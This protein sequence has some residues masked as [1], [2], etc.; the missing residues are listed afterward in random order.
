MKSRHMRT[1]EVGG[2]QGRGPAFMT[3][4]ADADAF[5]GAFC[6][7]HR[8][9]RRLVRYVWKFIRQET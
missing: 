7:L 4:R 1:I 5:A 8:P 3:S 9:A 6:G 2:R